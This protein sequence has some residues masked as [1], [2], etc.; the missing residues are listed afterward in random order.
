M[1]PSE[2]VQ[3]GK[4]LYQNG[5][6]ET[7]FQ[8]WQ[9]AE[10]AYSRSGDRI[11]ILGSRINQAEALVAM[12]LY[13]RSCKTL[14]E[15]LH[16][17]DSI[18]ESEVPKVAELRA[19]LKAEF[20]P[21]PLQATGLKILGETLRLVGNLE[22]SQAVLQFSLEK[23]ED[24]AL[25]TK[26]QIKLSLGNTSRDLGNRDRDRTGCITTQTSDTPNICSEDTKAGKYYRQAFLQYDEAFVGLSSTFFTVQAQINQLN[27]YADILNWSIQNEQESGLDAIKFNTTQVVSNIQKK[28]AHLDPNFDNISARIN[29]ARSLILLSNQSSIAQQQLEIALSHAR[30][31]RSR[32]A[33]AYALGTL[34]FLHEQSQTYQ[35]AI[36]YTQEASN[37]AG[38][39]RAYD[40]YYQWQWQLGRI[41]KKK[42]NPD[43]KG[44]IVAYQ[45]A[46]TALQSIRENL[47]AINP[48][49]QFS[50]RDNVEPVYRE[51]VDLVLDNNPTQADLERSLSYIDAL[52]LT[53]L[54]NF[55]RCSLLLPKA[56]SVKQV[57]PSAAIFYPIIL[58][59]RLE[60]LLQLPNQPEIVRRTSEIKRSELEQTLALLRNQLESADSGADMKRTSKKIYD[61][62]LGKFESVLKAHHVKTLVMIAD[63]NLR[64]I[65]IAALYDG[66]KYVVQNYAVASTPGL[67]ILGLNRS[68]QKRQQSLVVALSMERIIDRAGEKLSY[69]KLLTVG[70]EALNIQRFLPNSESLIDQ[71]F[72]TE[73]FRK[74]INS[75]VYS[76]VHV[77]THGQFSSNPS[78]TFIVTADGTFDINQ[79]QSWLQQRSRTEQIELLVFSACDTAKGDRR[80]ALGLAGVTLRAGASSTLASL[81]SA[82]DKA[83]TKLMTRFYEILHNQ[84]VTKAEALR[85]AQLEV[86]NDPLS[87]H[88]RYWSPFVLVGDWL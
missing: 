67:N 8:T 7:A 85:Q 16:F 88:P 22:G 49:A 74:K 65:P 23:A 31:I 52:Q 10:I 48:D 15:T 35:Q 86:L 46:I 57:D 59:D 63:G 2:I 54:E 70:E 28:L 81:W 34:G 25:E 61:L 58:K 5:Q 21:K 14:V 27:L 18:C 79:L 68:S 45:N 76:T 43:V 69:P 83:T 37:I 32:K 17:K 41:L 77:A 64:N 71:Q 24:Q 53:E 4:Q 47:A 38:S 60:V 6:F 82:N 36:S 11:G 50:L 3:Q 44:A 78:D 73:A 75:S 12:G 80:A 40:I 84:P 20:A 1:I 72:T 55:V 56:K 9:Q 87:D 51:L 26:A 62:L 19:F 29:F 39:L 13:R 42:Q 33:E 66:K 30:Q